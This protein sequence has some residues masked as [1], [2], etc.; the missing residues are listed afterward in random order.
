MNSSRDN[1]FGLM[2]KLIHRGAA[3]FTAVVVFGGL[4]SVIGN[5]LVPSGEAWAEYG[6]TW[7]GL[8]DC[9]DGWEILE[10]VE[11]RTG[12]RADKPEGDVA[13]YY[14]DVKCAATNKTVK[15]VFAAP[16]D[17]PNN[18]DDNGVK[19]IIISLAQ[20]KAVSCDGTV[21]QLYTGEVPEDA[22]EEARKKAEENKRYCWDN[23]G[24]LGWL[25]CPI[26]EGASSALSTIYENIIEPF[27][28][29]DPALIDD[30][31]S[32]GVYI[33]W[34]IF[35]NIAN[36]IFVILLLAVIFS[37]IT[38]WG[39]DN[40]GIKK[41]LPKLIVAAILIN[42]SFVICQL[43]VDLSNIFGNGLNSML[44]GIA[45]QVN[46]QAS[47]A[48]AYFSSLV[49]VVAAALGIV[50]AAGAAGAAFLTVTTLIGSGWAI[51]VPVL[52]SLVSAL[53]SVL[54]MFAVLIVRK[55]LAVLL[56]AVAPLA[57]ASYIFPNTKKILFD[58]WLS[59]FKGVLL[60]YP[61]AGLLI[62]GGLLA[63]VIIVTT[64]QEGSVDASS[65]VQLFFTYLGGVLLQVVP[66]FFL[67]S[68]FRKSLS[69]VG[70]IGNKITGFGRGV[71][72]GLSKRVNES[73]GIRAWQAEQA[74]GTPNGL[75]ERVASAMAGNKR[76]P[77]GQIARNA[78]ARSR[79]KHERMTS[80]LGAYDAMFGKD[81]LLQAETAN[82]MKRITSSGEINNLGFNPK[83][84][85][86][87]DEKGLAAGFR[88]ALRK[89]DAAGIRAYTDALATK[90][91]AGRQAIQDIWDKEVETGTVTG[92]AAKTFADNVLSNH[93]DFKVTNDSMYELAKGVNSKPEESLKTTEQ[94]L[95]DNGTALVDNVTAASLGSMDDKEYKRII[96]LA[97]S[98]PIIRELANEALTGPNIA[99]IN[100]QRVKELKDLANGSTPPT[101]TT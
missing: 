52:M 66:F 77:G 67:P 83:T 28:V 12:Q 33:A 10:K 61:L 70:D 46:A 2:K 68:L 48:S 54:F 98:H 13:G 18:H 29:I 71:N 92:S 89:N 14:V 27:L 86:I 101:S 40:Y 100:A 72:A 56:V 62:G 87:T 6:G 36:W 15:N 31:D 65:D 21:G 43:A 3:V 97:Q 41:I 11:K 63:S 26:I 90:G 80:M 32:S 74:A 16:E 8:P 78:L 4:I 91:S 81:Y 7:K 47:S 64:A 73:E 93:A 20:G 45:A 95:Q 82:E 22:I 84:E 9:K 23:S 53:L 17:M 25:I 1:C 75:R 35:R 58:R 99:S 49:Y 50:V 51:I 19:C 57:F 38:G 60:L 96:R 24:S 39:I 30:S 55:A 85:E 5:V 79:M 44:T 88:K 34:S 37:Q 94:W 59:I 76:L 42:L 69:A